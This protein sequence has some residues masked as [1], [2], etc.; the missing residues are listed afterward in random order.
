MSIGKQALVTDPKQVGINAHNLLADLYKYRPPYLRDFFDELSA[1]LKLSQ[2]DT[3]LDLCCGRGELADGVHDAVKHVF[4]VDGSQGMLSNAI[5]KS[6]I[7][8]YSANVND[9]ILP[10]NEKVNHIL[11][12]TAIHWIWGHA[13]NSILNQYLLPDGKVCVIHRYFDFDDQGFSGS[14]RNLNENYHKNYELKTDFTGYAKMRQSGFEKCGN[15]AVKATVKF[16]LQ[17]LWL[18]QRSLAY[19]HFQKNISN[20]ADS[21]KRDLFSAMNPYVIDGKLSGTLINWAV[22]Y[23]KM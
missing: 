8:F 2:S 6:N 11:I 7:A 3:V 16:G 23:S 1:K 13:I 10:I 22:I 18:N 17:Y 15:I 12:G 14:L 5:Q 4:A 20:S 19:G 21:Y 9:G